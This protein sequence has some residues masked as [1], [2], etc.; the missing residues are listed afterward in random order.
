MLRA[1]LQAA[2]QVGNTLN[3]GQLGGAAEGIR[4]ESLHRFTELK[5][6]PVSFAA[7]REEELVLCSYMCMCVYIC[8]YVENG[9]PTSSHA[10]STVCV[11]NTCARVRIAVPHHGKSMTQYVCQNKRRRARGVV[12][13]YQIC[14]LHRRVFKCKI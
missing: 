11:I 4:V 8:I 12:V 13:Q 14:R 3:A 5:V 1:A 6:E 10:M 7:T 2:L 9:F